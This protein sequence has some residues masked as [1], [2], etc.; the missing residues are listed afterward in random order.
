MIMIIFSI[1]N[2]MI[3]IIIVTIII[4]TI[5]IAV[6]ITT[7]ILIIVI[8]IIIAINFAAVSLLRGR[9]G[10]R[11]AADLA[12][13][14]LYLLLRALH[15]SLHPEALAREALVGAG[16]LIQLAWHVRG[17]VQCRHHHLRLGSRRSA[18]PP[19]SAR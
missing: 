18:P 17:L 5:I 16:P 6:I 9:R 11:V 1:I 13:H 7:T 8:I 4:L 2:T 3:I 14:L 10:E 15:V 19:K 12:K